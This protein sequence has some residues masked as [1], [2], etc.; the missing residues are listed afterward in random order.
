MRPK[1]RMRT[2]RRAYAA[3]FAVMLA[4]PATAVALT[5][6]PS[7][8][9]TSAVA[10]TDTT[11]AIKAN[12]NRRHVDYGETV[13]IKGAASPAQPGQRL[14]LR[15][16]TAGSHSW[17]TVASATERHDGSFR[18]T[19]PMRRSARLR[20]VSAA[21][22]ASAPQRVTVTARLE[23]QT[24]S[25]DVL[26]GHSSAVRGTLLPGIPGRKV[27]LEGRQSD[28]GWRLLTTDRTGSRG[29]F[30]LHYAGGDASRLRVHFAGDRQ[31]TR[32][33]K[34]AGQLTVFRTDHG[35][36][37]L[38]RHRRDRVRLPGPLRRGQPHTPVRDARSRSA[39]AAIRSRRRSTTAARSSPGGPGTSASTPATPSDLSASGRSGRPQRVIA[40]PCDSPRRPPAAGRG[41]AAVAR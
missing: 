10:Q 2:S 35:V 5:A 33:A 21:G 23:L 27:R 17:R 25:I 6:R 26:A 18:V 11:S 36:V 9:G 8:G 40:R 39:T 41:D 24:D 3:A 38:R 1:S 15:S 22:A 7:T 29:G 4:I 12:V 28:G 34:P 32:A 16:T 14:E 31:N 13:T 30:G 19:T 20:V 37:V